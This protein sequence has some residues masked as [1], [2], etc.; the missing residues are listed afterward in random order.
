MIIL[1]APE[2]HELPAASELCLRSKAYWGYDADFM[3]ACVEELTLTKDDIA[4]DLVVLA[5]DDD[6]IVGVAQVS[7]GADGCYLEKLFVEP[8]QMGNGV[9][10]KLFDWSRSAGAQLGARQIIVEADPE[11]VPFYKAM[12]CKDAGS[13]PSSSIPGRILPRLV[14]EI[15]D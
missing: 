8:A 14:C 10:R 2:L 6:A 4:Q 13:A 7:D 1:R 15:D 12:H 3:S 11:A 5:W 9:G